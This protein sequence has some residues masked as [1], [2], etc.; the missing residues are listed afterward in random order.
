MQSLIVDAVKIAKALFKPYDISDAFVIN[1]R[2]FDLDDPTIPRTSTGIIIRPPPGGLGCPGCVDNHY[3]SSPTHSRN[4]QQCRWYDKVDYYWKCDS[5]MRNYGNNKG[6]H[7]RIPGQ[8]RWSKPWRL[9]D[10]HG[11]A[12]PTAPAAAAAPAA[13]AASAA[14]T[15]AAVPAARTPKPG[16]TPTAGAGSY[17]VT[18]GALSGPSSGAGSSGDH[19]TRPQVI[20][21][22]GRQEGGD[23][24][25]P[26]AAPAAAAPAAKYP[27]WTRFDVQSS[28][29]NMRSDVPS[30]VLRELRKL[31]LRWFHAKEPKMRLI[32]SKM[33]LDNTRL[34]LI[35]GVCDSGRECRAWEKPSNTVMPSTALPERFNAEVECD[36]IF[37]KCKHIV[38][39]IADRCIRF[40]EGAEIP[41]RLMDTVLDAYCYTWLRHGPA[42]IL[43]S[44][45]EGA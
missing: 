25:P 14:S 44:D 35:K 28:L 17:D 43:Y 33:G 34:A 2:G 9:P 15:P 38:F 5:C 41:D 20:G 6:G 19:R 4:P 45:G 42:K 7:L 39:H 10:D 37:Y 32:L 31:H 30:V 8:C 18:R 21:R 27:D 22:R 24:P 1:S 13:S 26:P 40:A 16:D 29:R 36:L 23:D 3:M 11:Q 12:R